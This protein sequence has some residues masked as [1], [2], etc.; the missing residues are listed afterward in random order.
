MAHLYGPAVRCEFVY[1]GLES[2]HRPAAMRLE[3]G[4]ARRTV[5]I[6]N[7]RQPTTRVSSGLSGR[8]ARGSVSLRKMV[9][10][11]RCWKSIW[12]F[13]AIDPR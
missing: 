13:K 1:D 8:A 11:S 12:R 7:R 5:D 2:A 10:R 9:C 3:C 4:A 6:P